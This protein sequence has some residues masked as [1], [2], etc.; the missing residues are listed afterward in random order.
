MYEFVMLLAATIASAGLTIG[1]VFVVDAMVCLCRD[2]WR[3]I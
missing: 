2:K 3:D 1:S